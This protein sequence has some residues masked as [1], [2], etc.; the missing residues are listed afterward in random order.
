MALG[1]Q[2]DFLDVLAN[3]AG[4]VLG[5]TLALVWLGDWVQRVEGWARRT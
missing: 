5:L 1:R 4:I 3:S 2:R